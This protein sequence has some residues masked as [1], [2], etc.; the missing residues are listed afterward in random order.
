MFAVCM[1]L[2]SC[3]QTEDNLFDGTPSQRMDKE[4][5]RVKKLIT[6]PSNGWLMEYYPSSTQAYGGFNVL[7]K[8]TDAGKVTFAS[9]TAGAD[10]TATSDYE[11]TQSSGCVITFDT[12]NSVFHAYSTPEESNGGG[13]GYGYSGDFEFI[14]MSAS[15]DEI[16][17]KGRKTGSKARLIPLTPAIKWN[18]YLSAIKDES[19]FVA[20]YYRLQYHL[21]GQKYEARMNG[22]HMVVYQLGADGEW[23]AAQ[24]T[25]FIVT[26]TGVKF[27]EPLTMD[28]V[29]IDGLVFDPLKGDE[30]AWVATNNI[31]AQFYP[32]Y[33]T[34]NE[35]I[36]TN[37][38]YFACSDMSEKARAYWK[39]AEEAMTA[40]G[41]CLLY[42]N[43]GWVSDFL[44]NDLAFSFRCTKHGT[45][46]LC[47]SY[48][49]IGD[50]QMSLMF[51]K[52][53]S[54]YG[55]L[56]YKDFHFNSIL[57]MM[58]NDKKRTFTITPDNIKNPTR[59]KFVDNDDPD[60]WFTLH[61]EVVYYP[62]SN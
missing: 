39:P 56:H 8:F 14:V 4:M 22:R 23:Q 21:N 18:E 51:G 46:Y 54:Y 49:L 29:S 12:Y 34:V 40:D 11:F 30:G 36:I 57:T 62:F 28:N 24:N 25:P 35:L 27:Y 9:E 41:D 5:A 6:K 60:L 32:S 15:E 59:L 3:Q 42:A 45:G 43:T 19:S 31:D 52:Q 16:V 50:N 38:W 2:C 20:N 47:L 58:G 1:G 48:E 33:P 53:G 7:V 61:R 13:L 55:S 37:N 17:L 26:M 10:V 44:S